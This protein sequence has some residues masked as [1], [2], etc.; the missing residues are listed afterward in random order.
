[1]GLD[2]ALE[3]DLDLDHAL[4]LD[5]DLDHELD[6]EREKKQDQERVSSF[7]SIFFVFFH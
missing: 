2:H 1:M 3:P 6:H 5:L 7:A 4:E